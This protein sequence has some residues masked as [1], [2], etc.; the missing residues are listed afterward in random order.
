LPPPLLFGGQPQAR[1]RPTAHAA[2]VTSI[3][4]SLNEKPVILTRRVV[5]GA[6]IAPPDLNRGRSSSDPN[7]TSFELQ[8]NRN[9]ELWLVG[10]R[11]ADAQRTACGRLTDAWQPLAGR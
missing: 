2:A 10:V 5:P 9:V 3:P 7:R 8:L 1:S 4:I 11:S 6:Q